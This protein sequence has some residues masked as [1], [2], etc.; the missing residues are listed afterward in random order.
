MFTIKTLNTISQKGL[1]AFNP[2]VYQIDDDSPSPDAIILRSALMETV[3]EGTSA[4][5]RAG[6][7]VNNIPLDICTERGIVVFN[8]PGANANSVKELVFSGMLLSNRKIIEGVNW[9]RSLAGNNNVEE[10]VEGGKKNFVGPELMGKQ[11]TVIGLGSIGAIVANTA[12][13][14]G[15]EVFGYDPYISVDSAWGLRSQIIRAEK[16]EAAIANCDFISLHIPLTDH[17]RNIIN[18]ELI[19]K[20]KKG[21]RILNFSRGALVN[22]DDMIA[23]LK[24]GRVKRYITDFPNDKLLRQKNVLPTPHL[25]ASTPEA[26]ENCAVMAC[27]QVIQYLET[28]N[29]SNSVNFPNMN[30]NF[31][32]QN[33]L[34]ILNENI[35]RMVGQIT[36]ILA[37]EGINISDM[38]NRHRNNV[39]VTIID[40]DVDISDKN[41]RRLEQISGVIRVRAIKNR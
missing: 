10:A 6:A 17:S 24:T 38:I 14:L 27:K 41:I 33:R 34:A 16:L 21:V 31:S 23:A 35:P 18:S 11:L 20:M 12:V 4:I 39:A 40:T 13:D 28:G 25:G 32:T 29:I 3:P 1:A 5:A 2:A 30:L 8:T 26:E 36:G 19:S 37:E 15:M 9:V 22:D 7:G